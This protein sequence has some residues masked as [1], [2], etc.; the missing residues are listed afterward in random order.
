[1][2]N[3]KTGILAI[4]LIAALVIGIRVFGP[5]TPSVPDGQPLSEVI[6]PDLSEVALEGQAVFA[7]NCS[8]CHGV[9]AT[10]LSGLAPT[11]ISTVYLPSLHADIAIILAAKLGVRG[12][13]ATFGSMPPVPEVSEAES[14]KITVYIRELQRANGIE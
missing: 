9:N 14:Q 12:H 7:A 6:V 10:G 2:G 4:V 3:K 11:L 8:V 13:H 5:S 1:M